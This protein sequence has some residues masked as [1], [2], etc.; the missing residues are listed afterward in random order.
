VFKVL[1]AVKS[2]YV[3][4]SFL[5]SRL[6]GVVFM[7][8]K[9]D[10]G[11][12]QLDTIFFGSRAKALCNHPLAM[13]IKDDPLDP[14]CSS[15]TCLFGFDLRL[16]K[17]FTA[18]PT[19]GEDGEASFQLNGTSMEKVLSWWNARNPIQDRVKA[20]TGVNITGD[21]VTFPGLDENRD[22]EK[23]L[24]G[25]VGFRFQEG[26]KKPP[27]SESSTAPSSTASSGNSSVTR[28]SH[29]PDLKDADMLQRCR[30]VIVDLGNAC[31]THKHFSEDIQTRQYRA[32]EV[33]IG[34]K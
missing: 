1:F 11:N 9:R 25:A 19:V 20:F 28:V 31:W 34:T 30:A 8:Y 10:E 4:L 14:S 16:V 26:S 2:T 23:V 3:V 27:V 18:R 17:D 21:M 13:R 5:E 24:D 33:L 29:Q 7:T 6:P 22:S 12:P 15:A 32:P